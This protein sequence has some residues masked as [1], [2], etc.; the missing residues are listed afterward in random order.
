[1]MHRLVFFLAFAGI[2]Q[3][4][5]ASP[6]TA[7]RLII[8]TDLFS[9]VDDAGALLLAATSSS[10][11]L[12]AVNIN[13]PSTYSALAASAI[14]AHYG[15]NTPIGILRPL[16]NVTFFDSWFFELGEYT[17]KVAYHWSGGPLPWGHAEDAWDPV[18]LY[19]KILCEAPDQSVTIT[20]IGFFDNLSGLLNSSSDI[21][22]PLSGPD[23][24]AAKVSELV[25]MGGEYPSGYEYN[26]WGSNPSIT[27]HVVNTWKGSP[28]TFSG[29]EIGQNVTS[30]LRLIN[31]GPR[32][33][34]VKAA[35]VYYGYTT[36][37]PSFDPLTVLYAMEGLG[38]LFEF[39]VEYGY[40]HVEQNGSNKW[41]YDKG[42][43]GQRFL[44][45]KVSEHEA[46]V[47][48]DRRLLQAAWSTKRDQV[49]TRQKL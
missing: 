47:E 45:L 29:F 20:S 1:M 8:D 14:L 3:A 34:P 44:R 5:A 28:I 31:E 38:D 6:T 30:G 2:I 35:Y 36:A 40:N 16:S 21:Y 17:S 42:V 32:D 25:I 37:R 33:D 49:L 19:R 13:F 9:D 7:K 26:F 12:L 18:A 43:T 23:L 22:S 11:N 24:I 27:A 46:G 48:V 4:H 39:G 15:S 10:A 41:V